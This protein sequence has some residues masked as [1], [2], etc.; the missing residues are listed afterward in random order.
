[1]KRTLPPD[2]YM[3]LTIYKTFGHT[4]LFSS[5][6]SGTQ[7]LPS[8]FVSSYNRRKSNS[9]SRVLPLIQPVQN[10]LFFKL[11]FAEPHIT[12]LLGAREIKVTKFNS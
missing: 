8:P 3:T 12:Y 5:D 6:L 1:M 7:T 4:S 10:S 2:T 11:S 9:Q